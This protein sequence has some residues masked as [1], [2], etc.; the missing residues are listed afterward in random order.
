LTSYDKVMKGGDEGPVV[1]AGDPDKSLLIKALKGQ[2][3]AQM[4][5]PGKGKPLTADQI[6]TVSDW[7]KAGAKNG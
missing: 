4:P 1:V 3:A 6:Q 5:P 7:I 2:G